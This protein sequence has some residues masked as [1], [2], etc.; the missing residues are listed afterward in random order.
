MAYT[1]EVEVEVE[2][3]TYYL[4]VMVTMALGGKPGGIIRGGLMGGAKRPMIIGPISDDKSDDGGGGDGDGDGG[5][6][7]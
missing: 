6:G 5:G 3:V 1:L 4:V 2:M 7:G